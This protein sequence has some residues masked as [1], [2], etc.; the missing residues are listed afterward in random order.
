MYTDLHFYV[1]FLELLFTVLR[2]GIVPYFFVTVIVIVTVIMI[3]A[4]FIF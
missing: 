1:T 3:S 4:M 2:R